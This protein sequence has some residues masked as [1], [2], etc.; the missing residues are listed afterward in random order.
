MLPRG[1]MYIL[2]KRGPNT[3]PWGTP[4]LTEH[5]DDFIP[6]IITWLVRP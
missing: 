5:L 4:C 1:S 2:K 6:W 3:D